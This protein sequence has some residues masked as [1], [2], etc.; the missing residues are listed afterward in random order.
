[1]KTCFVMNDIILVHSNMF[2]FQLNI[3]QINIIKYSHN[4]CRIVYIQITVKFKLSSVI[5]IDRV[6]YLP[7]LNYLP[8]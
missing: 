7:T 1:M 3:I 2:F 6:E 8:I 5:F 4:E